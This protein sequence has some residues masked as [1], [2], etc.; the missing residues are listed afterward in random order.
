MILGGAFK[1]RRIFTLKQPPPDTVTQ[2]PALDAM[3]L[4]TALNY[5]IGVEHVTQVLDT[6]AQC[7][8]AAN[9]VHLNGKHDH[10]EAAGSLQLGIQGEA[11]PPAKR[12]AARRRAHSGSRIASPGSGTSDSRIP[13][14]PSRTA[15]A[16]AWAHRAGGKWRTARRAAGQRDQGRN[17][18]WG[19]VGAAA[20]AASARP[21]W[22]AECADIPFPLGTPLPAST[23][24]TVRVNGSHGS[25][26]EQPALPPPSPALDGRPC[27][28]RMSN[29]QSS[30]PRAATVRWV[31]PSSPKRSPKPTE[32]VEG[33][34]PG[35]VGMS[36]DKR[37]AGMEPDGDGA[38]LSPSASGRKFWND[39]SRLR[40][41]DVPLRRQAD[42][43]SHS[44]MSRSTLAAARARPR[45][46]AGACPRCHPP[47]ARQATG[48]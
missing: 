29:R 38:P 44:S 2:R 43:I 42:H 31:G 27:H 15:A 47:P 35:V 23:A 34:L 48:R 37:G 28:D 14:S 33:G 45:P 46:T 30:L 9:M 6:L 10:G 26:S 40:A 12:G 3:P 21:T 7:G 16:M 17:S 36:A 24:S 5:P 13:G 1:L 18:G 39:T 22:A 20:A 19:R 8:S 25:A 32:R 4:P 11:S 41:E